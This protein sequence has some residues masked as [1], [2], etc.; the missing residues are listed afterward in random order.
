MFTFDQ[1]RSLVVLADELHFGRAAERLNMTQPPLSRQI[2]K[3]EQELGFALFVRKNKRVEIT[4]AGRVFAEEAERLLTMAESSREIAR[5]IAAGAAGLLRIGITASGT[6]A[7]LGGILERLES[8]APGTEVTVRE[9]VSR[10]QIQSVSKGSIDL[11]FVRTDPT[12]VGLASLP[13]WEEP[14]VAAIGRRHPLAVTSR[15]LDVEDL[16]GERVL[17]YDP[18]EAAYFHELVGRLLEGVWT[19]PSQQVTQIHSMVAL[20]AANQGIA[21]VPRSSAR[22][23]MPGVVFRPIIDAE[24]YPSR[25][26]AVWRKENANPAFPRALTVLRELH[27]A[28]GLDHRTG[29]NRA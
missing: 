5:R 17:R 13:V 15:G 19:R 2:Q 12:A 6:Q 23:G 26:L 16:A 27:A 28:L 4:H 8:I 11:A 14:L 21:L 1:L 24:R 18:T 29:A 25:L 3:L 7:L 22:V 20:V 9:M 10:D